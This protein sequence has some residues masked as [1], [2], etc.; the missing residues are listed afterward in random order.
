VNI[1]LMVRNR[2]FSPDGWVYGNWFEGHNWTMGNYSDEILSYNNLTEINKSWDYYFNVSD[3]SSTCPKMRS[4]PSGAPYS[5]YWIETPSKEYTTDVFDW[6]FVNDTYIDNNSVDTNYGNKSTMNVK[7]D[8]L[9]GMIKFDLSS[10][11]ETATI[12][13]ATISLYYNSTSANSRNISFHR[14]WQ[15]WNEDDVTWGNWYHENNYSSS[16]NIAGEISDEQHYNWSALTD[17]KYFHNNSVENYGWLVKVNTNQLTEFDSK[18][19]AYASRRPILSVT[20]SKGNNTYV[21]PDY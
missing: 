12:E 4:V 17:V 7:V 10:I 5:Y 8:S 11:P 13:S 2:T 1:S 20:Y 9:Y 19:A 18:E 21:H 14:I 6:R 3:N 15:D 16:V